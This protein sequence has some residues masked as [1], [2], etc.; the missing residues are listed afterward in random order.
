MLWKGFGVEN[1]KKS[2]NLKTGKFKNVT[3]MVRKGLEWRLTGSPIGG[4]DVKKSKI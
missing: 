3:E 4:G 1:L 2:K